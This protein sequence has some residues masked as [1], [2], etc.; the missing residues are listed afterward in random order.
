MNFYL[1]LFF[2]VIFY[3]FYNLPKVVL[4]ENLPKLV[5]IKTSKANLRYG[6]G[7]NYPIKLIFIKKDI[8]LLV[9]DKFDHW[10]KVF[11]SKNIDGWI[12]KSQLSMKHRSIILRPDYLRK[13]PQL[14]SEKIAFLHN[15]VNVSVV[16]CM[17]YWCKVTFKTR[18]FSGW[19]IK[20]FLWGSNYIIV[21]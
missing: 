18:K 13:K 9:V 6:P 17:L 5:S 4:A 15:N 21:R 8:P 10:R 1:K 2:I 20:K 16:K 19:F 12:H 3:S 7:K 11:T 14:S